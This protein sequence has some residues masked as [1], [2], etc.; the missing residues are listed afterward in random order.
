[1]RLFASH[2]L[3]VSAPVLR[4]VPSRCPRDRLP[5]SSQRP[6]STCRIL[7][8][9]GPPSVRVN[10]ESGIYID[11]NTTS[12]GSSS[13]IVLFI[14]NCH[15]QTPSVPSQ[16]NRR[17]MPVGESLVSLALL[18]IAHCR[19]AAPPRLHLTSTV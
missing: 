8:S 13:E 2:D 17:Q 15:S 18:G 14:E 19:L 3:S 6:C 7:R 1:M 4:P 11:A 9:A 10:E 16:R 12:Q 5:N